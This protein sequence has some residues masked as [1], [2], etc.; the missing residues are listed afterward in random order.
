TDTLTRAEAHRS[1]D[2]LD[3]EI[4]LAGPH[5]EKAAHKPAAGVTRV[6]HQRT[7]DQADH[8][9]NIRA[10]PRQ[11]LSS[12]GEN[13]RVVLRYLKRLPS[14][15]AGPAA[16]CLRVFGPALSDEPHVALRRPRECRSIM[17][18]DRDC[19]LEQSPRPDH[20]L[21]C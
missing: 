5:P 16:A 15:I 18:I 20:P 3:P 1:L 17:R 7:V 6:E 10:E 4:G 11:H 21:F 2:T 19:L 12:I 13:A 9:P 8:R 14:E